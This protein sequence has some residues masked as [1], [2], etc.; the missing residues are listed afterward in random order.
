MSS[1]SLRRAAAAAVFTLVALAAHPS[2]AAPPRDA[3][4]AV[5]VKESDRILTDRNAVLILID[6][7]PQTIFGIGSH[8]R[9]TIINNTEALAR[10]AKAF[11]LPVILTTVAA[12]TFTGPLIPEIRRHFPDAEIIDRTTLNA[13]ADPRVVE[14]VKKTGRRKL[15]MAGTWTELCLTLPVISAIDAGYEVYIVPEASGGSSPEAHQMGVQRMV[16]AGA[17]P[18]TWVGVAS[19]LQYDWARKDT[20][21]AVNRI[22]ME[23]GGAFGAGI[24]YRRAMAAQAGA[25]K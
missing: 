3:G 24:N 13:W 10:T 9:Q 14:A 2:G 4:P 23:H 22:F 16:M 7:Q 8:D 18:V 21:E 6:H 25:A 1:S 17:V 12:D 15:I 5:N 19:E 11:G 20:Y